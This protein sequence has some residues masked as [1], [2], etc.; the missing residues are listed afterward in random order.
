MPD[1]WIPLAPYP[2]RCR[3]AHAGVPVLGF[4]RIRSGVTANL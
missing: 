2:I 1:S 4:P 3:V